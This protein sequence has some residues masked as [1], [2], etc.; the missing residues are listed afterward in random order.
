MLVDVKLRLSYI[1]TLQKCLKR[2]QMKKV[3]RGLQR[4]VI[5]IKDMY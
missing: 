5:R 4:Q 3:V 1:Y 2:K